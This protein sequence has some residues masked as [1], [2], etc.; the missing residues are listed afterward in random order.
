MVVLKRVALLLVA[1]G[2]AAGRIGPCAEDP[3]P[4]APILD[5]PVARAAPARHEV[6]PPA[7]ER[8]VASLVRDLSSE[9][10]A[11]V[12]AASKQLRWT[13]LSHD[14]MSR[15]VPL[16]W[17]AFLA[18]PD[19]DSEVDF[20]DLRA[21]IGSAEMPAL[22]RSLPEMFSDGAASRIAGGLHRM[23]RAGHLP[24]IAAKL[25]EFR[26]PDER[27]YLKDDRIRAL[28]QE[29][30]RRRDD[31]LW[32]TGQLM[33]MGDEAAR[34]EVWD[35]MTTGR[36]RWVDSAGVEVMTLGRDFGTIPCWID[37]LESNCCRF[38]VVAAI[39]E[40]LFGLDLDDHCVS[41]RY[42]PADV[43]RDFWKRHGDNLVWSRIAGRYVPG[44][45]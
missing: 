44:V 27:G 13:E 30:H 11:T 8:D 40:D 3:P 4:P 2:L 39:F 19:F 7:P 43:A 22:I 34:K 1:A 10:E 24:L 6:D 18:N 16:L 32:T 12:L 42:T 35:A 41:L 28:L 23:I 14:E 29:K 17:K 36:Y 21:M 25:A 33:L 9:D 20:D 15:I 5:P 45:R 26:D 38:N 37:E 31:R